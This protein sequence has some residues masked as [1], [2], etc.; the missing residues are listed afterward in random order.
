MHRMSELSA[1]QSCFQLFL[2]AKSKY[3]FSFVSVVCQGMPLPEKDKIKKHLHL[4][5]GACSIQQITSFSVSE[6]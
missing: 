2:T 3:S 6:E 1:E 4:C 5:T